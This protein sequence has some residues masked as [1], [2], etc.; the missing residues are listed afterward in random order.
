MLPKCL[1]EFLPYLSALLEVKTTNKHKCENKSIKTLNGELMLGTKVGVIKI[2]CVY[3]KIPWWHRSTQSASATTYWKKS[4]IHRI[5]SIW[6]KS[7]LAINKKKFLHIFFDSRQEIVWCWC[8]INQIYNQ[9]CFLQYPTAEI[10][11]SEIYREEAN[12]IRKDDDV[13]T[14]SSLILSHWLKGS[15]FHASFCHKNVFV[16]LCWA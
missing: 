15:V 7:H 13:I 2:I 12:K 9:S 14:F 5:I 1:S 10:R 6:F 3:K 8:S 11:S 4:A 16:E